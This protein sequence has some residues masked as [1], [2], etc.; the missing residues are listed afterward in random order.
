[1]HTHAPGCIGLMTRVGLVLGAGGVTG[2]G[3]HAGVLAAL[4]EKTGWDPRKADLALGT[5]AGSATAATLRGGLS[6]P[7]LY[8]RSVGEPL[9]S[10]GLALLRR[11]GLPTGPPPV[12]GPPLSRGSRWRG[13]APELLMET[14]IRA[15][16]RLR[17][18]SVGAALMPEGTVPTDHISGSIRALLGGRWPERTLWVAAVRL[19]DGL[20]VFGRDGSPPASPGDAV[21]AS[22]AIPGWYRP[23]V[24][25]DVRYVDGG[26]HSMTNVS[27]VAGQGLDVIVIS[28]PMGRAG[29]RGPASPLRQAAR[30]QLALE[31]QAIRRRGVTVIAFQPTAEDQAAIGQNPMDPARR[32]PAARQ[33]R[34]SALG[35]LDRP[36]VR[37]VLEALRG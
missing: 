26:V 4:H 3:F 9:S 14:A 32:A 5:S 12:P 2:G 8:A 31:V 34:L 28:A 33:A 22:C 17:L 24:I 23:V 13:A 18:G 21:A 20:V 35:R 37:P 19:G 7:D 30:A 15:P 36:D 1:M 27:Q 10:E 6:A 25:G 11:V 29:E 16:W